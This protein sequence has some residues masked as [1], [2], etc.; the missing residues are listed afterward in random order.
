M[1]KLLDVLVVI[2]Q[3][4]WVSYSEYA[5]ILIASCRREDVQRMKRL[6]QYHI[7]TAVSVLDGVTSTA[8]ASNDR[9]SRE[10]SEW[11][12]PSTPTQYKSDSDDGRS[13]WCISQHCEP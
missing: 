4:E 9:N 13:V 5:R 10:S 7:D 2:F 1:A 6:W 12:M 11:S 8:D 3:E